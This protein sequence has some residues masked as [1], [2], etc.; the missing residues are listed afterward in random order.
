MLD[1]NRQARIVYRHMTDKGRNWSAWGLTRD[2]QLD[3]SQYA[4]WSSWQHEAWI[5]APFRKY[6]AAF[7]R[8][9]KG[10]RPS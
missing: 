7:D 6:A 10:C 4:N 3:A 5:M 1:P 9:P 8:L 2:G